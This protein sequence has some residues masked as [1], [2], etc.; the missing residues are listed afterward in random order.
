MQ[1]A[2][3]ADHTRRS[4]ISV[5][6]SPRPPRTLSTQHHRQQLLTVN[7]ENDSLISVFTEL[8]VR[9][10]DHL[11]LSPNTTLPGLAL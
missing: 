1:E 7:D 9:R 8:P 10:L 6:S 11:R 2:A 4:D 3:P 5:Q